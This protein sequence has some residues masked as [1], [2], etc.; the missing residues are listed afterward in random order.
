MSPLK[1]LLVGESNP[2]HTDEKVSAAI[3]RASMRVVQSPQRADP[4]D[5]LRSR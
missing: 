1:P 4:K 2:Y 5:V 3:R